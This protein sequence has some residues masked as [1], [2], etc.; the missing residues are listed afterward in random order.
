MLQKRTSNSV[1][2][3]KNWSD[4]VVGFGYTGSNYW[5]GLNNIHA[6]AS[7]PVAIEINIKLFDNDI[8][9]VRYGTF[10]VDDAASNYT[11][12]IGDYEDN[13]RY[14]ESF[15]RQNGSMFT[16]QDSDNDRD[17]H[18]SATFHFSGGWWYNDNGDKMRPNALY[19]GDERVGKTS[20]FLGLIDGSEKAVKSVEIVI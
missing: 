8:I 4:Y 16:T 13:P 3:E 7:T 12:T 1:D 5:R 11:L 2:F 20:L 19:F 18:N 9:T 14:T 10:R 15:L 17:S 6:E